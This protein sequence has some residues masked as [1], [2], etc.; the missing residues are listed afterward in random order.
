MMSRSQ[1]SSR[2][3]W[4]RWPFGRGLSQPSVAPLTGVLVLFVPRFVHVGPIE[5][6]VDRMLEVAVGGIIALA[7]SLLVLPA[8]AHSFVIEG[9]GSD[10]QSDGGVPSRVVRGVHPASRCGCDRA[11]PGQHWRSCC[12]DAGK[13]RRGEARAHSFSCRRARS[14]T[15]SEHAHAAASR[16]RHDW[17]VLLQ[18]YW[19]TMRGGGGRAQAAWPLMRRCRTN[20]R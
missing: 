20:R 19:L 13:R 11:Y 3:R 14:W 8:R 10:A 4:R 5:S 7:V 16:P 6:A 12:A 17:T 2:S 15:A 9:R 18:R 1:A